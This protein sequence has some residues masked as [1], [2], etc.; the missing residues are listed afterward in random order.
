MIRVTTE[1]SVD[2]VRRLTLWDGETVVGGARAC[3]EGKMLRLEE[4]DAPNAALEDM[5]LRAT[6]HGGR[7]AGAE[8]AWVQGEE[9]DIHAFF[10]AGCGG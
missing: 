9:V 10:S 1:V 4:M 8:S 7:L 3:L 6:L 2:G 5:L